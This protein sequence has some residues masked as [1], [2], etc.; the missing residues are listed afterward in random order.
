MWLQIMVS[1][2]CQLLL[3]ADVERKG[4]EREGNEREGRE[5]RS[6]NRKAKEEEERLIAQLSLSRSRFDF[7]SFG[8]SIL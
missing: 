1:D 4:Q 2:V 3:V 6:E 7:L 8:L 5:I